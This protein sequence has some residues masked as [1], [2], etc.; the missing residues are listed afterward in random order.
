MNRREFLG[1]NMGALAGASMAAR[2]VQGADDDGGS[3]GQI[4]GQLPRNVQMQYMRPAQL[5]AAGR[6]F[7]VVYVPLGP[8]EWH[9]RH[10][11]A[12]KH[13]GKKGKDRRVKACHARDGFRPAERPN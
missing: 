9:G 12:W 11:T 5:D 3:K 1:T 7:P 8:I 13:R 6:K 2:A 10:T 4:D